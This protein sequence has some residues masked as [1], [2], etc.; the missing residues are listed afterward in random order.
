VTLPTRIGRYRVDRELGRGGMGVVYA[1]YD[2]QLERTVAIKTVAEAAADET[3][4][5]RLWREARA[6]ARIRH[7]N[8][9]QIYEIAEDN[10]ELFIA[11]E[12]LEGESLTQRLERGP[13]PVAETVE[14]C[15]EIL[16]ALAVLHQESLVH[17]DLKPSNIFLTPHGV[18]I[19]DFGLAQ[20]VYPDVL[21]SKETTESRLTQAGAA[22]GTPAYMA[23]EQLRG[24]PVDGRT[25]LF[26]MG[27]VIFEML[28]ATRAFAGKT[29]V[30]VYH[31]T[32][33][34]Q[35]PALSGSPAATVVD[36]IIRRAL[37]KRP[38]DRFAGAAEMAEALRAVRE[39]E[40]TGETR[41]HSIT[42]II[43][44]PFR[45]LRPDPDTDFLG[46]SVPDAIT[47]ALGGLESLVVRSSVAAAKF[48][49][50]DPDLKRIAEE[51]DV[52]VVLTGNLLRAGQYIRVTTQLVEVPEGTLLWSHAPQVTLRDV[53]QLQDQI[54]E[55][56]VESLSL[57]LTAR[58]HR[59]LKTDVPAT[60]TAYEL[61]LRGN[62]LILAQGVASAE[63]LSVAR[64][65][66]SRCVEE[67]PR[68]APGWAR[69]GRCH[70]LIGKGGEE[71]EENVRRAEECFERALE[72]NPELPIA[73][74][75]YALLEIDQGRAQDAMVRLVRRARSGSAQPELYAA[76]VQACR[77]C[78]LLEASVAA[79]E[80]AQQLDRNIVTSVDHTYW[81]LG[82]YA[83]AL[84]YARRKYRGEASV[85]RR[86]LH[87]MILNEQGRKD[88]AVR[89]LREIEQRNLTA[90]IRVM[91]ASTRALFEERREE[92]LE[93][94]EHA[95]AAFRDPEG[96][97]QLA[98]GLAYFG[99]RERALAAFNRSLEMGFIL[100]R[101]LTREDPW[102][103]PL[104][105]SPEFVDL[106]RRSE[107]LYREAVAVFRDAGGEELL[108]VDAE[109]GA[110]DGS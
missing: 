15:L 29:P 70:W 58:E 73:H 34:E 96:V 86:A 44:L 82:D 9:C 98:R 35:P 17:R 46:V 83:R 78:G 81:H 91:I 6:A 33:Y 59:R 43:V 89:L 84:E 108:G 77:F 3:A 22:V 8:V 102:L 39:V 69:L 28:M 76:L 53:F 30:E 31:K 68:Y 74:N 24:E 92:F 66:Y 103:D 94:A 110:N 20:S 49:V 85:T 4:R 52:D 79:H 64:D 67:D 48:A 71:L 54:V 38:E 26:A 12:L 95:I 109:I 2:D 42:R 57:S 100:Y 14:I 104:R 62:Q 1:A 51:A 21:H 56:I 13:L 18:K 101:I 105:S 106:V 19:L 41:A 5:K 65:L 40:D 25:D 63:N 27:A 99:E 93:E 16:S 107:S 10:D 45:V 32:L 36:R 90:L 50:E 88:E 80:R 11:M 75:L 60:P 55:H 97:W 87:A 23:P 37:A 47:N 72:L 7:P 61:F